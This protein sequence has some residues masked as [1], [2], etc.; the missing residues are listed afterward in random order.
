V[1][2]DGHPREWRRPHALQPR[3]AQE[4]DAEGGEQRQQEQADPAVGELRAQRAIST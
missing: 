1:L 4:D 2:G 3:R